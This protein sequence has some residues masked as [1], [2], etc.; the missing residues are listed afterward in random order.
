VSLK[1]I[2]IVQQIDS[3]VSLQMRQ[4]CNAGPVRWGNISPD[5]SQEK[6]GES[7]R[8]AEKVLFDHRQI[9]GRNWEKSVAMGRNGEKYLCRPD[10]NFYHFSP[11]FFQSKSDWR[12]RNE[13]KWGE[14]GGNREKPKSTKE[15]VKHALESN[16]GAAVL[17]ALLFN[18]SGPCMLPRMCLLFLAPLLSVPAVHTDNL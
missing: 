3:E 18:T 14:N 8:N 17:L 16:L 9:A 13:E 1:A 15:G 11:K 2:T 4:A 7:G 12:G 5:F 10:C 6:C